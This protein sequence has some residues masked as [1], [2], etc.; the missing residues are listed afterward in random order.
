MHMRTAAAEEKVGVVK[1]MKK[2]GLLGT[3]CHSSWVSSVP[4]LPTSGRVTYGSLHNA[5]GS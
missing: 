2:K 3:L 1:E 4:S 5:Q